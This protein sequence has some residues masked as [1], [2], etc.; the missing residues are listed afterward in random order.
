ML[1]PF[2]NQGAAEL[3]EQITNMLKAERSPGSLPGDDLHA[4]AVAVVDVVVEWLEAGLR[5]EGE[6]AL[7]GEVVAVLELDPVGA[8]VVVVEVFPDDEIGRASC[9]ESV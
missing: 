6:E 3:V 9:R 4:G 1:P 8:D 2:G 7:L 5:Q